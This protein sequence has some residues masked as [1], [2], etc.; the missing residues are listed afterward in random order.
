MASLQ[1]HTAQL[2]AVEFIDTCTLE[3]ERNKKLLVGKA[4]G[5][6]PWMKLERWLWIIKTSKEFDVLLAE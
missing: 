4:A 6:W 2:T 1:P 3:I 5:M